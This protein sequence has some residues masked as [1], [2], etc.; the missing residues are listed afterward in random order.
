MAGASESDPSLVTRGCHAANSCSHVVGTCA[1][2]LVNIYGFR[3]ANDATYQAYSAIGLSSLVKS[4]D[5]INKNS[6][7][8]L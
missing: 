4:H 2:L 1:N 3:Q 8:N 6:R 5:R 7:A